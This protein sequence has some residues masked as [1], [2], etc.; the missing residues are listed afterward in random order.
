[1]QIILSSDNTDGVSLSVDNWLNFNQIDHE[2]RKFWND[3]LNEYRLDLTIERSIVI[4][5]HNFLHCFVKMPCPHTE[6]I[7]HFKKFLGQNN[8]LWFLGCDIAISF[9]ESK[10]KNFIQ[11][12]DR[13]IES[14]NMV[15][16]LDAEPTDRCYLSRLQNIKIMMCPVHDFNRVQ[17]RIQA[18]TLQKSNARYDYLLTMIQKPRRPHRR[19]LWDQLNQRP[20][21]L[22]HGFV[23]C[24]VTNSVGIDRSQL[25]WA[26]RKSNQHNWNDG[27]ASMDLYSQCWLEIV[28]ETCY[29]DLYYFTEKTQKPIMTQT[30][31]LMVTTAGY[32]GWLRSCGFQT[33]DSL[34]DESYDLH[35]R[36]E[37]RIRSMLDVLEY[38]IS[39]G[40]E[41]FYNA[42]RPILEHNFSRLCEIAGSWWYESDRIMWQALDNATS[43]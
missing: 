4:F 7:D 14:S 32:L 8:Q 25:D 16:F 38:I 34:I 29:R 9:L 11:S 22:D 23:K 41:A 18:K 17:P 12:L 30:P 35:Y 13:E 33:F 3:H 2:Y 31:F 24:H 21:L 10:I 28:P 1:M 27:H 5:F 43:K 42:S 6:Q 36:M 19:W 39:N 37:D 40:T 26:G 20:K 15:L